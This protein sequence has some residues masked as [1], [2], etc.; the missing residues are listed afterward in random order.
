[1]RWQHPK[2]GMI[3]P[4]IFIPAFEKNGFI[5]KLDMY[6]CE[7]VCRRRGKEKDD[8]D[9]VVPVS[10]NLSRINFYK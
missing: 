9:H 5:T 10:V 1:M 6:V 7:E 2:K 8:D 4:G 3:S